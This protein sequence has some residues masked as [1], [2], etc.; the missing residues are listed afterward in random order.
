[1]FGYIYETTNLINN[2]KY[3]GKHKSDK[4]DNNYY[5]SGIGLKRA[6]NKY[7]KENFKIKIL[8]EID[9]NQHDL[10]LRETY[11]I[12]YYDAVKSKNYYNNSYGGENEGWAGYNKAIKENGYSL[13]TKERLSLSH[14]GQIPWNKGKKC[15][16]LSNEHKL[17][18]SKALKNRQFSEETKERM[19]K[20]AKIRT[21]NYIPWNKGKNISEE[22]KSKISNTLRSKYALGEISIPKKD[23][24]K[25]DRSLSEETKA[26]ISKAL[27][28]KS[29]S[30]ETKTKISKAL[31]GKNN[32]MYHKVSWNKGKVSINKGKI[33]VNN[34]I[35]N[36]LIL[37]EDLDIYLQNGWS[38]GRNTQ[39]Y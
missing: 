4:F 34:L 30:E 29:I 27:K 33:W 15:K 8:E 20:A 28:G 24:Y 16:A 3:I 36:K 26:K 13:E 32:P 5:G 2:K 23:R 7:G 18:L 39:K 1:M 14:K 21:K 6:L 19:S 9:T 37:P 31:K 17:K 11:W 35:T 25:K 22:T 10:D 38:K 12:E